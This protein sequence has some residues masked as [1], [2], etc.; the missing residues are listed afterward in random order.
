MDEARRAVCN[1]EEPGRC[2]DEGFAYRKPRA[3]SKLDGTGTRQESVRNQANLHLAVGSD[4]ACA[5]RFTLSPVQRAHG[6]VVMKRRDFFKTAGISSAALVSLPAF[7]KPAPAPAKA[8][9][10]DNQDEEH[11][12]G[13][14]GDHDEPKGAMANATMAFGEWNADPA[15]PLDRFPNNSPRTANN[16]HLLPGEVTI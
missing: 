10:H 16:H 11:D 6:G 7:A 12:H 4:L 8:A 1:N 14:G 2:P 9:P 15:A 3:I 13:H 5:G